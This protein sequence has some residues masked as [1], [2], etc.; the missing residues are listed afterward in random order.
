MNF[1]LFLHLDCWSDLQMISAAAATA[2][3]AA[4]AAAASAAAAAAERNIPDIQ[5]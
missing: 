3:A 5:C 2:T 1:Y 4:A